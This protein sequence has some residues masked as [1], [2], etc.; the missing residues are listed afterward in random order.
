MDAVNGESPKVKAGRPKGKT[1]TKD[2]IMDTAID[3]F[4]RRG[5]EAVSMQDIAEAVG[6]KKSSIYNH[7]KSKDQILQSILSYFSTELARSDMKRLNEENIIETYLD[8]LGPV[9]LMAAVGKQLEDLLK[10]SKMRKIWRMVAMEVYRNTMIRSFFEREVI[11][12]PARFWEK[13][14]ASMTRRGMIRQ[15]DVAVLAREYQAF[16]IY[17]QVKYLVLYNDEESE[18]F[19]REIANEQAAHI[20][21]YMEMLSI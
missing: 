16:Q 17:L 3:L 19:H 20:K 12:Q 7:F 6:I 11:D 13:A 21:F 14:F 5:Y 2:K 8:T 15:T 9:A 18:A 10:T 1:G 4:S